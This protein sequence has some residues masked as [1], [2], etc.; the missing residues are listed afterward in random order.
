MGSNFSAGGFP[1]EVTPLTN[2][3]LTNLYGKLHKFE[4]TV[5]RDFDDNVFMTKRQFQYTLGLSDKETFKLFRR[6]D[7]DGQGRISAIELW[8]AMALAGSPY[9]PFTLWY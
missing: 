3:D 8:G 5:Q 6:F 2:I 4:R 7:P 1:D 9:E